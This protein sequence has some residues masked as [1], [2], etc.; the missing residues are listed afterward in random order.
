MG[1]PV[2]KVAAAQAS[3]AAALPQVQNPSELLR[4]I[5]GGKFPTGE[6]EWIGVPGIWTL[7]TRLGGTAILVLIPTPTGV[8]ADKVPVHPYKF[9]PKKKEDERKYIQYALVANQ[10]EELDEDFE[11]DVMEWGKKGPQGTTKI[12]KDEVWKYGTTVNPESRYTQKWLIQN[13]LRMVRQ[14]E[15]TRTEVLQKEAEKIRNYRLLHGK[16]PPGN[17]KVG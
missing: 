1:D 14:S 5:R 13:K 8:G 10:D 16:L 12:K 3:A 15:G 11:H 2:K 6:P 17:K 4:V 7:L 9:A